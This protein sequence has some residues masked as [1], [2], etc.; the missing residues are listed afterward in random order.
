MLGVV[1]LF[2]VVRL[3]DAIPTILLDNP[4]IKCIEVEAP[5][6][7]VLRVKYNAPGM[8][9]YVFIGF[10]SDQMLKSETIS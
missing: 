4:L 9:C 10:H 7:T 8:D 5:I 3:N 6:D 2:A 1:L